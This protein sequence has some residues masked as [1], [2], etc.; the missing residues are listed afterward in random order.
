VAVAFIQEWKNA[1]PGT[2]N[3]DE[4]SRRLD[5]D[6]NPPDGLIAH[7]AG[8][9]SNGVWRIFDIW[10]SL[11]QAKQFQDERL[12]PIIQEM[13]QQRE[14]PDDDMPRPDV[15]EYYELHDLYRP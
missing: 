11:E 1:A 10:D 12:M 9:D 5:V 4:V 15:M 3:Y 14:Q 13:M 6:S 7:T 2:D 8:K